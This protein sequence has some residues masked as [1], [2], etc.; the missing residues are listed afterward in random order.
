ME[1]AI[2]CI[3]L[4]LVVSANADAK[5]SDGISIGVEVS[6]LGGLNVQAGY[7]NIDSDSYWLHHLGLRID[8][9]STDSLKS[10][11]DSV[12]DSYM[13]DGRDIGDGVKIDEGSLDAW[14]SGFVLDYYPFAGSWRMSAGYV[15]G[16]A[17]LDSSVF[18][19]IVNAPAQRF[20]FYLAGDHYYYNGNAFDGTVT[21]DWNYSGPYFG[22]GFDFDLGCRFG[23]FV[24][25]GVVLTNRPAE[26]S[27]DI[28]QD[29]LYIYNETTGLWSPVS[30]P[31]LDADIV[32]ATVEANDKLADWRIYPMVKMGFLYRF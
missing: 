26:L 30:I 32:R 1:R 4:L 7:R 16:G 2:F 27:L 19:E 9:A 6:A 14:H 31:Q 29:Q 10:A 23:L 18:G 3:S 25:V 15:W 21:I 20:Y 13:R 22:T 8:Y 17:R 5:F 28:S 11:I 12:I 24:D